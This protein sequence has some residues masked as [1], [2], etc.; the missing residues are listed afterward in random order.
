MRNFRK[1]YQ[2]L[3]FAAQ[4]V[5]IKR[6]LAARSALLRRLVLAAQQ[7]AARELEQAAHAPSD[8]PTVDDATQV[9]SRPHAGGRG[10]GYVAPSQ[11]S[12]PVPTPVRLIAFYLPQFH[13]TA[14]NDAWWGA[15]FTEWTLVARVLPKVEGQA[16]PKLPGALGFYDLRQPDV[17]RAQAQLA[18]THG[19]HGFCFYF[20]WFGGRRL[21]EQPLL[22]FLAD[23]G[24]DLPFCLCWA[25]E[26]WSRRWDGRDDDVL[27]AQQH[28]AEDDVAFID[29]A[30][31]Y[32]RDA[33]AIKVDGKPVLVIYRPSLLPDPKATAARWRTRCRELG[34]GEIHLAFTL[35]F[36]S[37]VPRD[38]G[39][40]AAIEFPPNNVV[41]RDITAQAKRLDPNFAGRVHDWRSLAAAP[42]MLPDDAGTLHRGVCPAWDNEARRA[43]RGRVFLHAAPRRYRDWLVAA[44]RDTLRRCANRESTLLFINAWNEWSEG[45]Y[46]EPDARLG[47]AWLEA[48]RAAQRIVA[49][50]PR[51]AAPRKPL[52]HVC[53]VLHAFYPELLDE[54]LLPLRTWGVP[55]R[56]LLST[57]AASEKAVRQRIAALG[58]TA[59]IQVFENRGRDMLPF[60][61]LASRL[62]DEGEGLVLKLHTKRSLHRG[63]GET[64]RRDL[65][66]K[67]VALD[68]SECILQA[69]QAQSALGM[70]VPDGHLLSLRAYWGANAGNVQSLC[71]RMGIGE[72]DPDTAAFPAGSMF[73]AR[74]E[75]LRPL[76]DTSLELFEFE[77]ETGQQDGTM[78][79]AIERVLG[80]CVQA[81]GMRVTTSTALDEAAPVVV[82]DYPFAARVGE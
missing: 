17:L 16:Q 49:A 11:D 43:G 13:P 1:F 33:R 50:S 15:G 73:Y 61:Q 77:P 2:A 12:E 23:A 47:Y 46:L 60:L 38:I 64:W 41:A 22:D 48:T 42:P 74:L 69:F 57:I 76:L 5:R 66:D 79:H 40:D 7:D 24:N 19:V 63:D 6:W 54:I 21:L 68:E 9:L 59:E 36:D 75:A 82:R 18:R 29:Y 67:L 32:L 25:N 31:R 78:A 30:A 45:A 55:Y 20:Y 81:A 39:F 58:M 52:R 70:V 71:R 44:M 72:I 8:A 80:L 3:P 4:R 14:E 53:V 26:P 65:L 10:I 51:V 34:I 37:F 62:L 27:I 35:A 28:G 56:L